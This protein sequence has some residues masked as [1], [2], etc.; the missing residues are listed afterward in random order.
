MKF[1]TR[2]DCLAR[3]MEC[4][5]G[6]GCARSG[7][8]LNRAVTERRT[9]QLGADV[10]EIDSWGFDCYTRRNIHDGAA[11]MPASRPP[12]QAPVRL[13]HRAVAM[14]QACPKASSLQIS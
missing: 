4:G 3:N 10:R 6:C 8:C 13:Q 5:P 7:A 9:L 2:C 11:A 12:A 14:P 1:E